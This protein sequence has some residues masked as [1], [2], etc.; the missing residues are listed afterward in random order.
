[1]EGGAGGVAVVGLRVE[2]GVGAEGDV[3]VGVAELPRDEH[4]VEP[5]GDEERG[6]RM[7]QRVE[8]YVPVIFQSG[9][10]EGEP[11][12]IP[13]GVVAVGLPVVRAEHEVFAVSVGPD[14]LLVAQE[15]Y[16]GFGE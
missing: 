8:A 9:T 15:F 5:C 4:H 11:K 2:V 1:L 3:G 16:D 13:G 7:P 6:V 14:G 10:S 12:G